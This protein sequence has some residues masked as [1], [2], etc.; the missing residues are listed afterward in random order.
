MDNYTIER[1]VQKDSE[2][3]KVFGGCLLA[4]QV[5]DIIGVRKGGAKRTNNFRIFLCNTLKYRGIEH[6]PIAFI[7]N[8]GTHKNGGV[9]WQGLYVDHDHTAYFFDSYGRLPLTEFKEFAH[10]LLTYSYY[11]VFHRDLPLKKV[12]SDKYFT[13]ANM[14]RAHKT[15]RANDHADTCRYFPYQIQNDRSKVCGEYA[16]LFLHNIVRVREPW[17]NAYSVWTSHGDFFLIPTSS[18]NRRRRCPCC[19]GAKHTIENKATAE[20]DKKTE[21][22][23]RQ[24]LLNDS[25]IRNVFYSIYKYYMKD[26]V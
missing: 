5:R 7:L 17:I 4:D 9:H 11:R 1:C 24:L 23:N 15:K 22:Q 16:V 6:F 12:L 3:Q 20:G 19:K 26:I 8:T 10:D 25:K 21:Y 14:K 2:L 18:N 13:P